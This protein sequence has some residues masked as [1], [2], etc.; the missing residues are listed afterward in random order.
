MIDQTLFVLSVSSVWMCDH[1][2]RNARATCPWSFPKF[3]KSSATRFRSCYTWES[4][5]DEPLGFYL[6]TW[7]VWTKNWTGVEHR[8][9]NQHISSSEM[10]PAAHGAGSKKI[11]DWQILRLIMNLNCASLRNRKKIYGS[12]VGSWNYNISTPFSLH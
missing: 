12:E 9:L 6:R 3:E 7:L 4:R 1:Y 11:I 10:F 5:L 8:P 2:D